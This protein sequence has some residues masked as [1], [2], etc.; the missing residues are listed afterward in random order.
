[1][2]ILIFYNSTEVQSIAAA[3]VLKV[4]YKAD[5]ITLTDLAGKNESQMTTAIST[6]ADQNRVFNTCI[7]TA[8]YS[9]A[10][11]PSIDVNVPLM[12]ARIVAGAVSPWNATISVGTTT[13][14][15]GTY[16]NPIMLAWLNAYPTVAYPP[17]VKYLGGDSA[18]PIKKATAT[19]A[20]A[21]TLTHTGAF[22]AS[23]HIGQFVYIVSATTGAGQVAQIASNT[24]GVLTLTANWPLTPTGTIVYGITEYKP[25]ACK[26]EALTAAVKAKLWNIASGATMA[27]W[28]RL[29]DLGSYDTSYNSITDGNLVGTFWD[30][31]LFN[32]LVAAGKA[33]YE[34]NSFPCYGPLEINELD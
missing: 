18:F 12:T 3:A 4:R 2:S 27:Q 15:A 11:H 19:S 20:A 32:G 33:A 8:S 34:Y 17:I 7:E 5:T 16:K 26:E 10:G 30:S 13:G 28:Y 14:S 6:G 9:A 31:K 21:G 24:T 29:L 1:M 23:A 22:T 25:D